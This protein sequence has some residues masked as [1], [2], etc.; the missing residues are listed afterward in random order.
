MLLFHLEIL[1][2]CKTLERKKTL[3]LLAIH[4]CVEQL[5]NINKRKPGD[6]C[7]IILLQ[8]TTAKGK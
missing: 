8:C 4:R 1:R 7:I 5:R 3:V 6:V 2:M